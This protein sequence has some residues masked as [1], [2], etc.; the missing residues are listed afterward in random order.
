MFTDILNFSNIFKSK[1]IQIF[2]IFVFFFLSF[3]EVY[4]QCGYCASIINWLAHSRAEQYAKER[5]KSYL[6][7]FESL[8]FKMKVY[9]K[10]GIL[11][12]YSDK[13]CFYLISHFDQLFNC[14]LFFFHSTSKSVLQLH[15]DD[16]ILSSDTRNNHY[17]KKGTSMKNSSDIKNKFCLDVSVQSFDSSTMTPHHF[18]PWILWQD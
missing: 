1:F 13:F 17:W 15:C 3:L 16:S 9:F 18:L 7:Y 11:I 5:K 2:I 6:H 14:H 8:I 10:K 4:L 12:L